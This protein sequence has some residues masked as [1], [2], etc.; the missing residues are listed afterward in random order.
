MYKNNVRNFKAENSISGDPFLGKTKALYVL[1]T[2]NGT[3]HSAV[4]FEHDGKT[5]TL[6]S[7]L[8]V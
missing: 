7:G 6:P 3:I 8:T 1:W 4:V 5:I 2:Q